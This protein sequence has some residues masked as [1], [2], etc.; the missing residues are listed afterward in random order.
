MS[1]PATILIADDDETNRRLLGT[2]L[3]KQGYDVK[4]VP[5]GAE[6]LE[7]IQKGGI[8]LVLLDV[9]MPGMSGLDALVLIR[10]THSAFELPVIMVTARNES[11]DVVAALE[12][13][14]N[15]YV[16]KPF[17]LPVLRARIA[18][19][20]RIQMEASRSGEGEPVVDEEPDLAHLRP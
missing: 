3:K 17:D 2:Y 8:D 4:A 18:A 12:L 10:Q 20:L 16:A 19:R 9:M 11:E 7:A 15:D 14:A 1:S 6:A 5:S 13:G